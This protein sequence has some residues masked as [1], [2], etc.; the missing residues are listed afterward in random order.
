MKEWGN[1]RNH[2]GG[3]KVER[4]GLESLAWWGSWVGVGHSGVK[5][6]LC[7]WLGLACASLGTAVPQVVGVL[8][9]GL[10]GCLELCD[11]QE[12]VP[13]RGL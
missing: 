8:P 3:D 11:P 13:L 6:L 4:P 10:S 1:F 2:V 7:R 9:E 5:S 12:A